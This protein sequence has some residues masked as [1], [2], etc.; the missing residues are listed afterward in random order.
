MSTC[1]NVSTKSDLRVTGS[2]TSCIVCRPRQRVH[3]HNRP[4][5]RQRGARHRQHH[6]RRAAAARAPGLRSFRRHLP[7]RKRQDGV[8]GSKG[9]RGAVLPDAWLRG[10]R[11]E[12]RRR[13]PAGTP[14]FLC[15]LR[16]FKVRIKRKEPI[17]M[18]LVSRQPR[19]Q[20]KLLRL[21]ASLSCLL[22]GMF[23]MDESKRGSASFIPFRPSQFESQACRSWRQRRTSRLCARRSGASS[24]TSTSCRCRRLPRRS[25]RVTCLRRRGASSTRRSTSP[26]PTLRRS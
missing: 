15:F 13:L 18:F 16:S 26:R 25:R 12:G 4:V 10:H 20:H 22:S 21:Q 3:V 8:S 2:I 7:A 14:L 19:L 23:C 11:Q 24:R 5:A 6:R 1:A 9:E 17:K